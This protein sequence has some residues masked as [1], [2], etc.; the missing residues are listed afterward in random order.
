MLCFHVVKK[1]DPQQRVQAPKLTKNPTPKPAKR[2]TP[3]PAKR[4]AS[5]PAPKPAR[6][7]KRT[8]FDTNRQCASGL[9]LHGLLCIDSLSVRYM[10][11]LFH[12]LVEASF[13]LFRYLLLGDQLKPWKLHPL[14]SYTSSINLNFVVISV[15]L[16]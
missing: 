14:V 10:T 16:A 1:K 9:L 8:F 7:P 15:V 11:W 3:K 2:P 4:P 12:N 13:D 6:T 5:K